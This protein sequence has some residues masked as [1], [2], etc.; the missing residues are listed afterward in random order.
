MCAAGIVS[1]KIEAAAAAGRCVVEEFTIC[2][3]K[4]A[5]RVTNP[6]ANR[7]AAAAGL[8]VLED[9]IAKGDRIALTARDHSAAADAERFLSALDCDSRHG[10]VKVTHKKLVYADDSIMRGGLLDDCAG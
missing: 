3:G 5:A 1:G 10:K 7:A 9:D 6:S 2:A 4:T 8:V